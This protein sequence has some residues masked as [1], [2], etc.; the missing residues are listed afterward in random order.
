[1]TILDKHDTQI[2][3]ILAW[4]GAEMIVTKLFTRGQMSGGN[5]F[6]LRLSYDMPHHLPTS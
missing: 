5:A 3:N 1:M 6:S 2:P 4:L